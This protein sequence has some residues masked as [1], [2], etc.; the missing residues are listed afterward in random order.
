[1]D[2][3]R[4]MFAEYRAKR[5]AEGITANNMNREQA[6]LCA[7]FN[8]LDRLGKWKRDNPLKKLRKFNI[9]DTE[10]TYL[11]LT[12]IK[13]LLAELPKGRNVH[14][15]LITKVCLATG[16]RW[17]EAEGLR[18]SQVRNSMTQFVKTKSS[19]ARSVPI[20]QE[21]SKELQAH[22]K[23]HGDGERIFAPAFYAFREGV[24]RA[25]L[26]LPKGQLTHVLRHSFVSA[27]Q[28]QG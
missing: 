24:E 16:A 27:R 7:V 8:E 18:Q 25:E 17:G 14:V 10:L 22:H 21:L 20:T 9:Q 4:D 12:E 26:V 15:T 19:K 1:M 2:W 6:Y 13:R 3:R 5:M 11:T 28:S 23:A